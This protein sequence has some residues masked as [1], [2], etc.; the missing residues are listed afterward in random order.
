[1]IILGASIN[2]DTG[3]AADDYSSPSGFFGICICGGIINEG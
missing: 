3:A 1:V 2:F